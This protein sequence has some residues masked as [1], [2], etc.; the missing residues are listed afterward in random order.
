MREM[1]VATIC[2]LISTGCVFNQSPEVRTFTVDDQVRHLLLRVGAGSVTIISG[3]AFTVKQTILGSEEPDLDEH[4]TG[5]V[6]TIDAECGEE[7][8]GC[9][10]HHEVMVRE[11]VNVEL[12][13]GAGDIDLE[14]LDGEVRAESDEGDIDGWGLTG[15]TVVAE[16]HAGDVSIELATVPSWADLEVGRGDVE[17]R[18]PSGV[19]DCTLQSGGGAI[20]IDNITCSDGAASGLSLRTDSGDVRL[21][22]R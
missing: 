22:G 14:G 21:M 19:Y 11:G 4:L 3:D 1:F 9:V 15:A 6:L 2:A 17:L 20:D 10:I 18:V 5:D 8:G 12:E 16:A 7:D 13:L